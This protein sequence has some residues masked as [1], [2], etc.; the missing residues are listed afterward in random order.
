[1]KENSSVEISNCDRSAS[2]YHPF[3]LRPNTTKTGI[4]L[5]RVGGNIF[6][7]LA[8]IPRTCGSRLVSVGRISMDAEYYALKT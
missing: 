3:T 4:W 5:S 6:L 7:L 8:E 1:M 2:R